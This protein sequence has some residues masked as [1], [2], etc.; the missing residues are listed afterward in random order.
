MTV[1]ARLQAL[2]GETGVRLTAIENQ[3]GMLAETVGALSNTMTFQLTEQNRRIEAVEAR[4]SGVETSMNSLRVEL[5]QK[6]ESANNRTLTVMGL[7][8][9]VAT[10]VFSGLTYLLT[11]LPLPAG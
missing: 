8:L 10:L 5:E 1:E 3:M 11:R 9:A 4:M 2:E 6:I 7:M